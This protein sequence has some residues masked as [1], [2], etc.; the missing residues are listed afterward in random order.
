MPSRLDLR[1]AQLGTH[2]DARL[3]S[4]GRF[5]CKDDFGPV[6]CVAS[7]PLLLFGGGV[8]SSRYVSGVLLD[9]KSSADDSE[10]CRVVK[11]L[12]LLCLV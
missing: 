6:L 5:V 10:H 1:D 8:G 12:A 7:R 4:R 9:L 3:G 2:E 11:Y